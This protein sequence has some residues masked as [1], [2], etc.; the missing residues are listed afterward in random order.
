MK[1]NATKL[2][3]GLALGCT[4]FFTW[5]AV[6]HLHAADVSAATRMTSAWQYK[7]FDFPVADADKNLNHLASQGWEIVSVSR[8]DEEIKN[9]HVSRQV[10]VTAK[11]IK[12]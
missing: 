11:I 12:K 9:Q 5:W 10:L 3:I 2:R 1:T 8:Y 6:T 4:V 7:T